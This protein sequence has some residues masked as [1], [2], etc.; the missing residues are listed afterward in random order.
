M[1]NITL[2]M[3]TFG[4]SEETLAEAIQSFLQQTYPCR[5][6]IVNTRRS[7]LELDQSYPTIEI[8][9]VEDTFEWFPDLQVH[10]LKQIKTPL[11]GVLDDDDIILPHHVED[12]VCLWKEARR[13]TRGSPL[14]VGKRQYVAVKGD[15]CRFLSGKRRWVNHLFERVPDR[16]LDK[17]REG[18][19]KKKGAN[20]GGFDGFCLK[21]GR[22]KPITVDGCDPTYLCRRGFGLLH[23][24][25]GGKEGYR[26]ILELKEELHKIPWTGK[27]KPYWRRDYEKEVRQFLLRQRFRDGTVEL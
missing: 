25:G 20:I 8:L 1:K 7:P 5:L 13:V 2:L 23:T 6:L 17:Y 11:W 4:R 3:N 12:L 18:Y 10:S 27:I 14:R 19:R 26:K 9:N 21:I 24:S 16:I 15:K 22:P